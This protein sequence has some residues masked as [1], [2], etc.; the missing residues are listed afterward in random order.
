[1]IQEKGEKGKIQISCMNPRPHGG[2]PAALLMQCR[3]SIANECMAACSKCTPYGSNTT[4]GAH[5]L[6]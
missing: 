3:Y 5:Q 6:R 2:N 1:M 4:H